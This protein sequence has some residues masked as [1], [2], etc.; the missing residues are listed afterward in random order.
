VVKESVLPMSNVHK[1]SIQIGHDLSCAT[2]INV[3]HG[4]LHVPPIPV[5]LNELSVLEKGNVDAS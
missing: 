4:I 3:A 2:D 1:P 5:K